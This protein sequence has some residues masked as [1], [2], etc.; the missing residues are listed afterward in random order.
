MASIADLGIGTGYIYVVNPEDTA[1]IKQSIPNDEEGA[2]SAKL[3]GLM[4]SNVASNLQ[5][6]GTVTFTAIT[7]TGNVTGIT[8]NAITQFKNNVPF[9][10]ATTLSELATLVATEV[11]TTVPT[12]GA[13][14]T[15]I[16]IGAI[17][18]LLAPASSGDNVN[19]DAVL[20]TI[21]ANATATTTD[22]GG[23]SEVNS[24]SY[25][26]KSGYRFFID[27]TSTAEVDT[28][29][30]SAVEITDYL[31]Q[32]GLETGLRVVAA[33]ISSGAITITRE[34]SIMY[35][36]L[37]GEGGVSDT[38]TTINPVGFANGDIIIVQG[39]D[40]AQVITIDNT[41]NIVTQGG[42]SFVTGD[43][44]NNIILG[45]SGTSWYE[46]AKST[47]AVPTAA[48]F[49]TANF[50]LLST[51][52]YGSAALTATDNTTVT[53]TANTSK[54]K[55]VITG[56]V[57]LTTGNYTVAVSTTDAKAGDLFYIEYNGAV[58]VGSYAVVIG[59]ITL[60]A[61]D[62]LTGGLLIEA[63][64]SGSAWQYSIYKDYYQSAKVQ[65]ADIASDSVTVAKVETALKTET[66]IIPVS[67]DAGEAAENRIRMHYAGSVV[68]MTAFTTKTILDDATIT[69][70]NTSGVILTNGIITFNNGDPIDTGVTV[71]PTANNSFV[72]GDYFSFLTQ[73]STLGGGKALLSVKITR[74]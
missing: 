56:T 11:N 41:G 13:N 69:A 62:A 33:T 42:T 51:S 57:S 71:T 66:L 26:N 7:G 10:I 53:L 55:Q 40:V 22:I 5:A 34:A 32:Q 49:R 8:V 3:L 29:D 31:C 61:A 15:A 68:E 52:G 50:P 20:V 72:S 17:V 28:V 63:Y 6:V 36:T 9:T 54:Q 37:R 19:G 48:Q 58:T 2:R 70:K 35:V 64:Y 21:S 46:I 18:Y 60:T 25:D 27:P 4:A 43:A 74:A 59:G 38:L 24:Y 39:V 23:G 44:S 73:T 45:K 30:G 12:S 47:T 67:W 1:D 65:T 14:Y 16:A